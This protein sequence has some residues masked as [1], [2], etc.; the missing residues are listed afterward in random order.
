MRNF[1]TA[2]A[3]RIALAF[4]LADSSH[5]LFSCS[6]EESRTRFSALHS[7]LINSLESKCRD[8]DVDLLGW[9][10]VALDWNLDHRPNSVREIWIGP[11]LIESAKL[12]KTLTIFDQQFNVTVDR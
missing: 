7:V 2:E 10:K 9:P 5:R 11:M 6:H 12:W 4:S 3:E 8:G 1:S